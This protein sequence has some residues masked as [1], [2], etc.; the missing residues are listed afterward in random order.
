MKCSNAECIIFKWLHC[1]DL[2][3]VGVTRTLNTQ[4]APAPQ[5]ISILFMSGLQGGWRLS[6]QLKLL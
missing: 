5:S 6:Q 1:T 2:S 4:R 3:A